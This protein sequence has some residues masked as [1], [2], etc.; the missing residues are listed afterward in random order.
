MI[1]ILVFIIWLIDI[2]NIDFTIGN[3]QVAY[4]L[5]EAI[6]INFWFWLLFWILCPSTVVYKESK[7]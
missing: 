7:D 3:I 5:D 4:Y 1:Q 6:P 2:L